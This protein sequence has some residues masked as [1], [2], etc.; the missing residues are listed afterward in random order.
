MF[1]LDRSLRPYTL[2]IVV[3]LG[4]LGH[5]ASR[6]A[7]PMRIRVEPLTVPPATQPLISVVVRNLMEDPSAGTLSIAGPA[8]WRIAPDSRPLELA[9][10]AQKRLAFN[11]EKA[12]NVAANVYPFTIQARVGDRL[13]RCEQSVFVASAPYSKATIDG[14]PDEWQDA[15]PVS[16]V[17]QDKR[18]TISTFWQ[19]KRFCLL[20]AVQEQQ[21]VG[22]TGADGPP[23]D[24]VQLAISSLEPPAADG[25]QAARRFEFVLTSVGGAAKCFQLAAWDTPRARAGDAQSLEPLESS[26]VE[27][28]IVRDG[29]VTYYECSLP[30][31]RLREAIEPAEGR[32]FFLSVLVHDPDG[33]GLRDLGRAAGLWPEPDDAQAWSRWRGMAAPL[34]PPLGNQVRWGLCTSKY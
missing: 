26:D 12:R 10:T 11:I 9:A 30:F 27:T 2:A 15:I 29:E 34:E 8:D 31:S 1:S 18:T 33:T 21:L 19:R 20:V 25:V 14:R 17:Q 16:F 22:Y 6:G 13:V 7:E 5:A 4:S 28:A 24:A 3:A 32:E 23:G